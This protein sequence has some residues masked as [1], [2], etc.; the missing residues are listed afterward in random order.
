MTHWVTIISKRAPR[1]PMLD[2]EL[3]RMDDHIIRAKAQVLIGQ[4]LC[5]LYH[6]NMLHMP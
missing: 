4:L 3:T 1:A 6:E 5:L 2:I